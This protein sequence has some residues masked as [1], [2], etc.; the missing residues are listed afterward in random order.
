MNSF[1]CT[2]LGPHDVVFVDIDKGDV[3]VPSR[4][5][6]VSLPNRDHSKLLLA[7]RT[8]GNIFSGET[9]L[10]LIESLDEAFPSN[11]DDVPMQLW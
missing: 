10:G 8:W 6:L 3:F 4:D 9:K 7:L 1:V 2:C 11:E 5:C